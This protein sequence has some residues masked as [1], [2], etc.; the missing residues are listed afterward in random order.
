MGGAAAKSVPFV[1]GL[2]FNTVAIRARCRELWSI[3]APMTLFWLRPK[4]CGSIMEWNCQSV[5]PAS[6][7]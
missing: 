5:V 3:S 1:N 7:R 6:T 4:K 2:L